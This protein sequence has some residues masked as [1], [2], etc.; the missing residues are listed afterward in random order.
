MQV[1]I[2]VCEELFSW[3]FKYACITQH[4]NKCHFLFY[5]LYLCD[6]HNRNL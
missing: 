4:M 2:E 1:G 5:I 3:L 6:E